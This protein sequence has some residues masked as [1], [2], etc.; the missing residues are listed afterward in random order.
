M[1]QK[2]RYEHLTHWLTV[3]LAEKS[4]K[5][6]IKLQPM[7]GDAGFRKY[8]RFQANGNSYIA[9][10]SPAEYCNNQ[11]FIEV[12]KALVAQG[13]NVPEII[14]VDNNDGF[15][16]LSDFGDHL[17]ADALPESQPNSSIKSAEVTKVQALYSQAIALLPEIAKASIPTDRQYALPI[18]DRA[19]IELELSIFKEWLLSKHLNIEL[20]EHESEQLKHCFDI[21]VS[22]ALEQPQVAMHRDF[23][24]RNIMILENK[25]L[26]VIDFQDMVIGPITYDIVSLLRDCYTRWPDK[27]TQPLFSDFCRLMAEHYSL[28]HV[29]E[30]Q[31]NRWFDLMGLQR[32]IKASGIFCRLLHRDD[33]SGYLKDVPLTLSYIVDISAKFPELAFLHQLVATKV[34]PAFAAKEQLDKVRKSL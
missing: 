11:A 31:W 23:H 25:T 33:K 12:Q 32:H 13:I 28:T 3:V 9:V 15:F 30:Q 1:L 21:I 6:S 26:G 29:S 14:A 5:N 8:Y 7:T 24:S 18:Y 19:F 16:C 4:P 34:V 10:D 20:S 22:S 17:L 27:V 2:T